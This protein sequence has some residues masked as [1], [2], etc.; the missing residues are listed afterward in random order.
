MEFPDELVVKTPADVADGSRLEAVVLSPVMLVAEVVSLDES[1]LESAVVLFT[2]VLVREAESF[3]V[4]LLAG[5][6]VV[7]IFDAEV[8]SAFGAE[9][10]ALVPLLVL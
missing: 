10:V 3:D 7:S 5:L 9:V 8:V 1:V 6:D 4:L 2:L